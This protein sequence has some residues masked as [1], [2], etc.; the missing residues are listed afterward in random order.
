MRRQAFILE[1]QTVPSK[2]FSVQLN[3]SME[4]IPSW[5]TES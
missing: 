1:K 3:L 4:N 2:T 5:D